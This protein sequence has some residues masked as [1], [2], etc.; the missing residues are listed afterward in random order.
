MCSSLTCFKYETKQCFYIQGVQ[1][2]DLVKQLLGTTGADE[3][4]CLLRDLPVGVLYLTQD[5][6]TEGGPENQGVLYCYPPPVQKNMLG[7]AR[8]AFLTLQHLLPDLA[9]SPP[10]RLMS[11]MSY[12]L[13]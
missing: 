6:L 2:S 11:I 12:E 3:L 9:P 10:V 4:S 7:C 8:G 1:Q 13:W 5:G